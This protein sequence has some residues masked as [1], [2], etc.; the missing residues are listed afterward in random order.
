MVD[1]KNA[2]EA[3]YKHRKQ[4]LMKWDTDH[5]LPPEFDQLIQVLPDVFLVEHFVYAL[6]C[7]DS[8]LAFAIWGGRGPFRFRL[9]SRERSGERVLFF[10]GEKL[11]LSPSSF[12]WNMTHLQRCNEVAHL[13]LLYEVSGGVDLTAPASSF[14]PHK[15]AWSWMIPGEEFNHCGLRALGEPQVKIPVFDGKRVVNSDIV[16]LVTMERASLPRAWW[17]DCICI[18]TCEAVAAHPRELWPYEQDIGVDLSVG[19][20]LRS[21]CITLKEY[22]YSFDPNNA[23][24]LRFSG[25]SAGL[26]TVGRRDT[27]LDYLLVAESESMD[28][29]AGYGLPPGHVLCRSTN[30]FLQQFELD[31]PRQLEQG[32]AYL[33]RTSILNRLTAI[34]NLGHRR[35]G[36]KFWNGNESASMIV[37]PE[38]FSVM[39]AEMGLEGLRKHVVDQSPDGMFPSLFKVAVQQLGVDPLSVKLRLGFPVNPAEDGLQLVRGQD[40]ETNCFVDGLS[41]G[42]LAILRDVDCDAVMD[43]VDTSRS[44]DEML[45]G[46]DEIVARHRV[47]SAKLEKLK[48]QKDLEPLWVEAS[49]LG[50]QLRIYRHFWALAGI[51]RFVAAGPSAD[52][53]LFAF[54]LFGATA[55]RPYMKLIPR[56][57]RVLMTAAGLSI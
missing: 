11:I 40:I 47:V 16:R 21:T 57:A 3:L 18:A 52:T 9:E 25:I 26:R 23:D 30:S 56:S 7:G 54:N 38:L 34:Q 27:Y 31:E 14:P 1:A 20:T 35:L 45:R 42:L 36:R 5:S 50:K 12:G 24:G 13:K 22:A 4:Q 10:K 17:D 19:E 6:H 33:Q 28:F 48:R 46:I 43:G 53:W 37:E 2:F 49:D 44:D 15:R 41:E 32:N 29:K 8:D 51:D 55:I 39:R